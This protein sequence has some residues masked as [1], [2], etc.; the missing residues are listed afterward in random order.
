MHSSLHRVQR[1][2][3][4]PDNPAAHVSATLHGRFSMK[5]DYA[6][7]AARSRIGGLS[8]TSVTI[9]ESQTK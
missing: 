9:R 7:G 2:N 3:R 6:D 5:Y 4:R 8:F 1:K